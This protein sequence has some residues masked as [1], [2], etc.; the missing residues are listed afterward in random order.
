[1]S[2]K[3]AWI[4][5]VAFI[6]PSLLGACAPTAPEPPPEQPVEEAPP[7]EPEEPA[8]PEPEEMEPAIDPNGQTV[9]FWH[10]WGEDDPSAGLL[11]LVAE[12]NETNEYGI[13]VEALD[14]GRYSDL[15][16][17]MNAAIQS[18][19]VP[20]IVVGYTNALDTWYSVDVMADINAYVYDDYYGLSE[21]EIADFYEGVWVNGVNAA[22]ARVG[23]PHGQSSNVMFYN[24]TW[25]QELGFDA[26]P[27]TIDE[28]KTQICA[29]AAANT[30]SGDPDLE[31]TGG[32]VLYTGA[33]NVA[34]FLF[35]LGGDFYDDAGTSY[36]FTSPEMVEVAEFW[37]EIWDEGCAFATE[38][39]PNP[40]FATR[41]ALITMS[42]TAGYPYQVSAFEA[43]GAYSADVWG[44]IPIPG[45][46]TQAVDAYAQNT[47]IVR[48]TPEQELA[49]W[50]FIKWFTSPEVSVKWIDASGYHPIRASVPQY[51]DDYAAANPLW[52][53]GL[54]L[55]PLGKSEPGWA[56]WGTVRREV[57]DSF[58]AVLQGDP[59]DIPA[60]LADLEA[61]ANE[62]L[63]ETS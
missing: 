15:E 45:K 13:T 11:G 48:S 50:L 39:Y 38:S 2:K 29:A 19:D 17:S 23:F 16:D 35:A 6:I 56:S 1:M 57:R 36:N 37:K 20:N 31:G 53:E 24:H 51:L 14:Q 12:F 54:A 4:L 63:A 28:L 10:V 3:F 33:E 47:G 40:E 22:G 7:P 52:A 9:V 58:S 43:E 59:A 18:G 41:K 55:G 49:A 44:F 61:A 32:M 27:A 34:A 30:A 60:L 42:S 8:E 46:D 62:A 25:A 5:L 21:E 26:P